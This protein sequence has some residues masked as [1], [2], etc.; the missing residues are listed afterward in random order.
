[1]LCGG[2]VTEALPGK[3]AVTETC[4]KAP[5]R[6]QAGALAPVAWLAFALTLL[7]SLITLQAPLLHDASAFFVLI[8]EYRDFVVW[9]ENRMFALGLMEAP[10]V[11]ALWLGVTDV[12]L[13]EI[14][15]GIGILA[16][17]PLALLV[18]W[19]LAPRALW[20]PVAGLGLAHLNT[21]LP[22]FSPALVAHALVWPV[23]IALVFVRPLTRF[24]AVALTLASLL[25]LYSYESQLFLGPPLAAL[26][27]WRLRGREAGWARAALAVSGLL[28]L[29]SM[30]VALEGIALEDNGTNRDSYVAG[31]LR[32]LHQP[33]WT[34]GYSALLAAVTLVALFSR[35][36][37]AWLRAWP[38]RCLIGAG[39]LAWGLWPFL[40]PDLLRPFDPYHARVLNLAVPLALLPVA[41]LAARHPGW[42]SARLH[43]LRVGVLCL[44]L[45]QSLWHLGTT[46]QWHGYVGVLRG[47][48]ANL[49]GP[50]LV[51]GTP[52]AGPLLGPQ[53]LRFETS[54][55]LPRLTLLLAPEG[56]VRGLLYSRRGYF[57]PYDP[58]LADTL[59]DLSRY[60]F[61]FTPYLEALRRQEP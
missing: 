52:L 18:C 24:A 61:D 13:L 54:W 11:L 7:F 15:F 51:D 57:H 6:E 40:A 45:A 1:M 19:R 44:L 47:A 33:P 22:P 8:L 12:G 9:P 2:S 16:A 56:R 5:W 42:F 27:L 3:P 48:L 55:S 37:V 41:L 17:W 35:R 50:L 38:A 25:L 10:L 32:L 53:S 14:C 30:A 23:L 46:L 29:G 60:G 49:E 34:V 4:A 28:L 59:P 58:P 43:L 36:L 39:L 26:A 20:L 31:A 21:S